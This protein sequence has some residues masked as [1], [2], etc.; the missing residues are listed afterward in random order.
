MGTAL[1]PNGLALAE[2]GMVSLSQ[3]DRILEIDTANRTITVEAG[4]RVSQVGGSVGGCVLGQ[5][6]CAS[7]YWWLSMCKFILR[8]TNLTDLWLS[9][10][11]HR[12]SPSM[13]QVLEAL[14]KH[15]LTLQNFSSVQ[16]QQMGGWTQVGRAP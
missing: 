6:V 11:S 15:G 4:A 14:A 13:M 5:L 7:F 12:P 3:L 9:M 10:S 16:E 1:S 2:E 8:H